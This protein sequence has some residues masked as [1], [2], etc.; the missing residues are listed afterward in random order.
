MRSLLTMVAGLL[1]AGSAAAD[2]FDYN[3]N[4]YPTSIGSANDCRN[5]ARQLADKFLEG[6]EATSALGLCT[7]FSATAYDILIRYESEARMQIVSSVNAGPV[8]TNRGFFATKE[9]CD[10]VLAEE[11]EVFELETGLPVLF[12]PYCFA[13]EDQGNPQP[14]MFRLEAVGDAVN[15]PRLETVPVFGSIQDFSRQ[16]FLQATFDG[17]LRLGLNPRYAKFRSSIGMGYVVVYLYSPE[18]HRL[19]STEFAVLDS[20]ENCASELQR[21]NLVAENLP[22]VINFCTVQWPSARAEVSSIFLDQKPFDMLYSLEYF[23]SYAACAA[24][25]DAVIQEY[26]GAGLDVADGLCGLDAEE[27]WKV[28]LLAR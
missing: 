9:D 22:V 21:F 24:G 5:V 28:V 3:L 26:R 23:S 25:R 2:Q 27:R 20:V 8:F 10:A 18:N 4:G 13:E 12:E 1:M 16:S 7:D 15:S 14:W 6:T 17:L 19:E 11:R